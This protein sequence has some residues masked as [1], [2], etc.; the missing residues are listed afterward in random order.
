MIRGFSGGWCRNFFRVRAGAFECFGLL[1]HSARGRKACDLLLEGGGAPGGGAE[2]ENLRLRLNHLGLRRRELLLQPVRAR[3]GRPSLRRE[4][5]D[6]RLEVGGLR[7]LRR[8]RPLGLGAQLAVG[9]RELRQLRRHSL[10][11]GLHLRDLRTWTP[12]HAAESTT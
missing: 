4:L 9:L 11:R 3:R 6:A 8:V 7:K 10:M 2:L 5:R 12:Q 1:L